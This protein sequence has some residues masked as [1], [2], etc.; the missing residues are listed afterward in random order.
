M[1][2]YTDQIFYGVDR[3]NFDGFRIFG[4][5]KQSFS[6]TISNSNH[7][8]ALQHFLLKKARS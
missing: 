7:T 2:K 4:K 8:A 1:S 3:E 5:Q 6:T